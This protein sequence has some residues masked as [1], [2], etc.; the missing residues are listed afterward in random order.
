V[1]RVLLMPLY[2]LSEYVI[3]IPAGALATALEKHRIP[4]KVRHVLTFGTKGRAGFYP[5]ALIDFGFRPSI[6]LSFFANDFPAPNSRFCTHFAW[7]GRDWWQVSV[8]DRFYFGD[9]AT[10][11]TPLAGSHFSARFD[12][13]SRPDYLHFGFGPTAAGE[14]IT[15]FTDKKLGGGVG[16]EL[17]F[18]HLDGLAIDAS[19]YNHRLQSGHPNEK[20]DELSIE[21][22]FDVSDP[23]QVPGWGGYTLL[24]AGADL[25]LD[26]R[27]ARPANGSGVRLEIGGDLNGDLENLPAWFVHL[28]GEV[29]AFIDLNDHNRVLA[30]RHNIQLI[31]PI[32]GADVPLPEQ[33]ALG[34][35]ELMRGFRAGRYRGLSSMVTTVQYTYP[36]W[37]FL[38]GLVFV[39][40]GNVFGQNLAGLHPEDWTLSFG[41]GVRS[42]SDRDAGFSVLFA[43]GTTPFSAD[44]FAVDAFRLVIGTDRG[45]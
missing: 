35:P 10:L 3:R 9:G 28:R 1:P 8:S 4:D 12:Y 13:L 37:V 22:R 30:F 44:K 25:T 2:A 19:V 27:R 36:I 43:A 39:E 26:S 32:A 6:G 18:G 7:G 31:E 34:G 5:T 21:D 14:S 16:L 24:T 40:T 42:N 41:M 15:R 11:N 20:R 38:D 29:G 17:V 45:F 33:I 23:A